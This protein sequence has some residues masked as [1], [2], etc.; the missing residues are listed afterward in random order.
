MDPAQTIHKRALHAERAMPG[1]IEPAPVQ[2]L[3]H[4]LCNRSS[5]DPVAPAS[6]CP[7]CFPTRSPRPT[8]MRETT[9]TRHR[10]TRCTRDL[11]RSSHAS[12]H[13]VLIP[14]AA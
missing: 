12:A 3:C 1:L 10:H 6:R 7:V 4:V 2:V 14:G 9:A 5:Q 8:L 13:G 11:I